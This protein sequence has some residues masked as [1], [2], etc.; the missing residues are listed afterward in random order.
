MPFDGMPDFYSIG[1]ALPFMNIVQG[2]RAILLGAR[3]FE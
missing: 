3:L 2:S 1:L